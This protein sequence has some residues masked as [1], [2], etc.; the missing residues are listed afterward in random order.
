[1]DG[2]AG[3]E[4]EE[5]GA[6]DK[7]GQGQSP[8][9]LPRVTGLPHLSQIPGQ[10]WGQAAWEAA[11][12]LGA[13]SAQKHAPPDFDFLVLILNPQPPFPTATPLPNTHIHPCSQRPV[14]PGSSGLNPGRKCEAIKNSSSTTHLIKALQRGYL[15]FIVPIGT[16]SSTALKEPI[17]L[18]S[19]GNTGQPFWSPAVCFLSCSLSLVLSQ[20]LRI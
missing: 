16:L 5:E 1:M 12:T 19:P 7:G 13:C 8:L 17:W 3:W 9:R 6:L 10:T 11:L 14:S 2:T 15:Q 18:C 20:I 4:W